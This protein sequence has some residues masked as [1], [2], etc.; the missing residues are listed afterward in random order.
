MSFYTID[1]VVMHYRTR[2]FQDFNFLISLLIQSQA[3]KRC[4]TIRINFEYLFWQC[5]VI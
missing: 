1:R 4:V 3:Q 2:K 5:H